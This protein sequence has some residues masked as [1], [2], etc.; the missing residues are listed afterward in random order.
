MA[1]IHLVLVAI[2]VCVVERASAS[3]GDGWERRMERLYEDGLLS[4]AQLDDVLHSG[5]F[6]LDFLKDTE[7]KTSYAEHPEQGVH[8]T[9]DDV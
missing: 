9:R 3:N 1:V 6:T 4:S 2:A 5:L 7:C 8:S